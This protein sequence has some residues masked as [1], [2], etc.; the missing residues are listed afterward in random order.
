MTSETSCKMIHN[1]SGKNK[2][3]CACECVCVERGR[4]GQSK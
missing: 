2:V 4:E 1:D 3:V